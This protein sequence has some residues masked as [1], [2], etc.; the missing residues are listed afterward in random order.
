MRASLRELGLPSC[1]TDKV[2]VAS[3][4]RATIVHE[5]DPQI[6]FHL[7]NARELAILSHSLES[8]GTFLFLTTLLVGVMFLSLMGVKL[9]LDLDIFES[10]FDRILKPAEILL[11]AGLPAIG[12]A[13][14]GV[15]AQGEFYSSADR[16]RVT[17]VR[18]TALRDE[19]LAEIKDE[20]TFYR[21][22]TLLH[23]VGR[24]MASELGSWQFIYRHR[25]LSLPA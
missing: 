18:L 14:A 24:T 8:V 1:R 20:P 10:V 4:V 19:L 23:A 22:S 12:A 15:R 13:I 21:A 3:I 17:A 7:E 25:P 6:T 9:I 16:S 11:M 2:Y 5:I